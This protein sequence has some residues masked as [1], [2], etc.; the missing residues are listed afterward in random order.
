M[1]SILEPWLLLE[2]FFLFY[3]LIATNLGKLLR[4]PSIAWKLLSIQ[5]MKMESMHVK[6][7]VAIALKTKNH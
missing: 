3:E 6:T 7:I 1:K 4:L 2:E 5:D